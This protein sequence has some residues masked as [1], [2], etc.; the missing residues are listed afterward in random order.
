MKLSRLIPASLFVLSTLSENMAA[1]TDSEKALATRYMTLLLH[2]I[3]QSEGGDREKW[4]QEPLLMGAVAYYYFKDSDEEFAELLRGT[5]RGLL[6]QGD[7]S[8]DSELP[9]F[10]KN[11]TDPATEEEAMTRLRFFGF[12]DVTAKRLLRDARQ[13]GLKAFEAWFRA[14][15][16]N[17]K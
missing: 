3:Q 7:S 17:N 13:D 5:A 11:F 4:M 15:G 6:A 1:E 14:K 12:D 8:L 2:G 16:K 9:T 10:R